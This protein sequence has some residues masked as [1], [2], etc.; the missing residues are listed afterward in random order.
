MIIVDL[1]WLLFNYE[2]CVSM[3]K[4]EFKDECGDKLWGTIMEY[5]YADMQY[6]LCETYIHVTIVMIH[7]KGRQ[8]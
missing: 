8:Y 4:C 7:E 3:R 2:L 5:M 6:E 1:G